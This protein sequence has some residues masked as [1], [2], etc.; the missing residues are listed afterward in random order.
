M[1]RAII[2]LAAAFAL[3]IGVMSMTA[4]AAETTDTAKKTPSNVTITVVMPEPTPPP[5]PEPA[6]S[7]EIKVYP[8]DVTETR[9]GGVWHIV[10]TYE[11][12][13]NENPADIPRADFER[14]GY[15]F[16][17]TDIIRKETANAETRPHTETVTVNTDTK[18]LEK[19]LPLL[20][21][22]M[23]YTA[24]D[25]FVGILTLDVASIKVETAGTKTSSYEMKVTREYPRLST[26]DTSLVPKTVTEKGKTYNL[27]GVDWRA[28]NYETVDYEQVA[29]YYTAVATYTATGTSTKVTGYVTT[30]IYNGTLAK[31]TQGKTVYT[32]YFL[33]EE[34]RTPLEMTELPTD[35]ESSTAAPNESATTE[36]KA[37]NPAETPSENAAATETPA[38]A[39]TAEPTEQPAAEPTETPPTDGE[40]TKSNNAL[41]VIIPILA[42]AA[43]VLFYIL[44]FRKGNFNDETTT[45]TSADVRDD[46]GDGDT[47]PRG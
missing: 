22:T 6:Q 46:G 45:D 15:K 23:E 36:N 29:E 47:D 32:A 1:K 30:A 42:A 43:G 17:L 27:A 38:S 19:I 28:G 7:H 41:L 16:T 44:K 25:G 10:K 40:T 9:E 3:S 8:S 12:A 13:A 14:S 20:S 34:I 37:E 24:E 26:N 4:F 33:G 18:E 2:T 21:P 5:A 11:L 31:L 35:T 39:A